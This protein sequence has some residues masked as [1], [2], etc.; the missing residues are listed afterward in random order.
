MSH[1]H[2]IVTLFLKFHKKKW[3]KRLLYTANLNVNKTRYGYDIIN[4]GNCP[5]ITK[6]V[7]K[8]IKLHFSA[9][10][11]VIYQTYYANSFILQ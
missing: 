8:T 5:R 3:V 10:Y 9:F 11:D 1:Q 2:I 6:L 7:K 4:D